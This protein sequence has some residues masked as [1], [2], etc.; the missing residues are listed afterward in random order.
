MS[1]FIQRTQTG[2]VSKILFVSNGEARDFALCAILRDEGFEVT[3]QSA[4]DELTTSLTQ[5]CPELVLFTPSIPKTFAFEACRTLRL[6]ADLRVIG[7]IILADQFSVEDRIKGLTAGADECVPMTISIAE[8]FARI[9]S[10]IRRISWEREEHVIQSGAIRLDRQARRVTS[11]GQ[12]ITL[13]QVEYRLLEVLMANKG[14]VVD[15]QT[16]VASGW[17]LGAVIDDG[18][19]NV[20]MRLLRRALCGQDGRR[21]IRTV[22]GAGYLFDAEI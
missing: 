13:G 21:I 11:S 3:L 2:I 16:L 9:S 17:P 7:I 4:V 6:S 10:L 14:H 12:T 15:R 8:L 5:V 19:I 20:Y 22:R 1:E 18:T